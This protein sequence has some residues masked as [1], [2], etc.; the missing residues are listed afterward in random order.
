MYNNNKSKSVQQFKIK[1][2][3]MINTKTQT[4]AGTGLA[5][6]VEHPTNFSLPNVA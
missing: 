2:I 6:K 4:A 5:Y 3:K 1:D